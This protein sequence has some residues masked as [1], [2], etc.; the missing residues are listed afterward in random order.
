MNNPNF[1]RTLGPGLLFSG[2]AVGVSHLVQSTRAGALYSLALVGVI[3]L[4]SILKY[5]AYRFGVD[6]G[7]SARR[8]LLAG[9][10]E[11]GLWAPILFCLIIIPVAPIIVA[12]I[13]ATTAGL[14][15]ALTGI[16][17]P[18]PVLVFVVLSA[19]AFLIIVGGYG[20]LDRINRILMV[21]LT[22]ATLATTVL[23]LPRIEWGTLA[24]VSWTSDPTALLFIIALA[25][26]LPNPL[27]IS[28]PQSIWTVEAEENVAPQDRASLSDARTGFFS[29]Y[30]V[31][32]LLAI[33]FCIMGAGVMHSGSMEPVSDAV[34]FATQIVGLYRETLG[35][36]PSILAAISA[37]AVMASTMLVAFDAYGKSFTAAYQEIGEVDDPAKLRRAYIVIVLTVAALAFA[38]LV[39]LLADFGSFVDLATSLAFLSA[40]IIATLNHLVVTR[41]AMPEEA[42]PSAAI[43]ALNIVAIAVMAI[44]TIGFFVL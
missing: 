37:L 12:A 33:C 4:I 15:G 11:L 2:A 25:G 38:T 10:K 5:P 26:F 41:C 19:T 17:A 21:F 23:V 14:L 34:G 27:D 31:T 13:S 16:D 8:S 42:R 32:A 30:V 28:I 3:I 39:F 43:K 40:P 35:T 22:L 6:Y 24:D 9:Y 29:G 44:M 36:V 18:L 1:W 7:Q 20:W